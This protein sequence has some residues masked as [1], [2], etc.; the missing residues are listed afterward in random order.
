MLC[1]AHRPAR[2]LR[3]PP[4]LLK[5]RRPV[6]YDF[7]VEESYVAI[8][9]YGIVTAAE[10]SEIMVRF[11]EIEAR[12]GIVPNRIADFSRA[13]E[14]KINFPQIGSYVDKLRS[15][16]W[17]NDVRSALIART[18][19]QFG[20]ARMF[21]T[22]AEN[23]QVE[24]RIFSEYLPALQ[25]VLGKEVPAEAVLPGRLPDPTAAAPGAVP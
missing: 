20:V 21:Q 16:T 12:T 9:F 24:V 4:L 6:P 5:P 3:S 17:K 7:N 22:M 1:R 8:G 2:G 19:L 18:H 14:I 11:R 23:T 25:W 10:L 13:E 15:R